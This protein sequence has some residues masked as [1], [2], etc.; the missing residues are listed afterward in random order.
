MGVA[1]HLHYF[2]YNERGT[3]NELNQ[4]CETIHVYERRIGRRGLSARLPYIVASRIS[5][6]LADNLRKDNHP[7]LLEG[8]HCTGIL[9][10]LDLGNRKVVVRMHNNESAYYRELG[11]AEHSFWKKIYFRRESRLISRYTG[12]LPGDCMYACITP[13]DTAQ[14]KQ[15]IP[16]AP[17]RYLPA[18][19]SW[20][21]VSGEEGAGTLCLYHGNLSV[22]ENEEAALWLL[23]HVFNRIKKPFVIAG[24][25]PSRRLQKMAH[26]YQH[27]CLV[28]D[29]T[30]AELNDLIRKAH[31]NLLPC[32]NRE[33]TGM[34]LKLLH[35]LFEGRHCIANEPMVRGTGLEGACHI[36]S[37]AEAF[38]SVILQ[39]YHHP[40]TSE[41]LRLREQLLGDTFNNER[42]CGTL[43]QYLW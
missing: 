31:I 9:P 20:Q 25:Q 26:L 27:T 28:A 43:I 5:T 17:V 13:A 7:I 14:L 12:Q 29:P 16:A 4:Y 41:E 37:G 40:F 32:F 15:M 38:A 1:I 35:V 22:P 23:R 10:L 36:A 42:N 3:P 6:E 33:M 24:K 30:D 18:F 21:K 11:R 34:R 19:P 2:S 8:I 39:L